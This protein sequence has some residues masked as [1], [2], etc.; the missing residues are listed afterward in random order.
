M[1]RVIG[2]VSG[3]GGVG[4][5]TIAANLGL[6]LSKFG[7][8]VTLVDCNVTTSHLGFYF[9]LYEYP[10]TLNNV[11]KGETTLNEATYFS[12]GLKIIPASLNIE[13][14]IGVDIWKLKESLSFEGVDIALLDSSPGLGKEA[15]S[16]LTACEEVIFVTIPYLPAISDV[17]KYSRLINQ[18]GVKPLGIVLNMVTGHFHELTSSDIERLTGLP[19]ISEVPFDRNVQKSLSLGKPLVLENPYSPAS[20][21]INKLAASLLGEKYSFPSRFQRFF[22]FF[23]NSLW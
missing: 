20:I 11:L 23:K 18:L 13:D 22:H 6:A 1:A 15:L 8:E 17:V 21:E 2:I 7:K 19:V 4:K 5:T 10:K 12:N 9:G 14:L 3:K 16:V